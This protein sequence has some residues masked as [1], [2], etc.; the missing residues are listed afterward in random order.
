MCVWKRTRVQNI[1]RTLRR[2]Q[3]GWTEV[4]SACLPSQ[5]PVQWSSCEGSDVSPVRQ[6]PGIAA[7]RTA[8]SSRNQDPEPL[9]GGWPFLG[10]MAEPH[11]W[12]QSQSTY[13]GIL[14]SRQAGAKL[15]LLP[16]V[17][18][19][20]FLREE[21]TSSPPFPL[22]LSTRM[23]QVVSSWG[24]SCCRNP[25]ASPQC[26]CKL[27]SMPILDALQTFSQTCTMPQSFKNPTT[28]T[29]TPVIPAYKPM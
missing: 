6:R 23:M 4:G 28:P 1:Q 5:E 11:F 13:K 14:W 3:D 19:I 9:A 29:C 16:G 12:G 8:K 15:R 25:Y 17:C 27:L 18:T 24:Q 7:P 10:E 2:P 26:E 21:P 20:A 22:P